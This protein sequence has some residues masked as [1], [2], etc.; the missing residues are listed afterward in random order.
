MAWTELGRIC[1]G[2]AEAEHVR[3]DV[4]S[5]EPDNWRVTNVEVACGVWRGTFRWQ[6]YQGELRRFARQVQELHRRLTGTAT[7]EP[8]EP[9]L[10]LK[11]VGDGKGHI[12]VEGRAEPE[13]CAGTYLVFTLALDQTE[14]PPIATELLA[15]DPA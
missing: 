5:Q 1:V 14:L 10:I 15:A 8:M 6:F 4:V 13:F 11:M 9:N 7:L 2:H 12:A 3:I